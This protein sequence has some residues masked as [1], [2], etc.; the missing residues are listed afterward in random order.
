M[1]ALGS[2]YH[3]QDTHIQIPTLCA[4]GQLH[5]MLQWRALRL[6]LDEAQ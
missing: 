2:A 5:P 4:V 1:Q 6:P 3:V